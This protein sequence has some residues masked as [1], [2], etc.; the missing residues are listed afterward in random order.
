M[1]PGRIY[2]AG[3]KRN[4][5]RTNSLKNRCGNSFWNMTQTKIL[6]ITNGE[7]LR[8][9]SGVD[10]IPCLHKVYAVTQSGS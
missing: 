10:N 5:T 7:S 9:D 2:I 8:Y 3:I 1:L 6:S 4:K